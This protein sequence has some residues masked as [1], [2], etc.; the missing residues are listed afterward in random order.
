MWGLALAAVVL[1]VGATLAFWPGL[2]RDA[3]PPAT[4][5]PADTL[6]DDIIWPPEPKKTTDVFPDDWILPPEPKITTQK[7]TYR[8]LSNVSGGFQNLRSGPA[9]KYK[10][11]IPIPAGA[12]GI[13]LGACRAAEDNT[14]SWCQATWRGLSG[15]ISSCCIVDE[16]TGAPPKVD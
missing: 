5:K 9:V 14:R 16:T 13:E 6:P 3:P 4:P 7:S 15:W 10:I 12:T 2:F 1:L 11:V 8:V